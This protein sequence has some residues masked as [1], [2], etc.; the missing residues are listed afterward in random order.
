MYRYN[1]V[2][3]VCG[4]MELKIL[5]PA[6]RSRLRSGVAIASVS[7]C[8]GELVE[9]SI[10]ASATCIAIRVDT[11]KFKVQ[12]IPMNEV[13]AILDPLQLLCCFCKTLI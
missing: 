12:V 10:D 3:V 7:Q 8:V 2:R 13:G 9:N 6:L 1:V 11:T 4:M 5:E